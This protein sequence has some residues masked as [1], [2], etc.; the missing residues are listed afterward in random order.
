M[1]GARRAGVV[2][3]WREEASNLCWRYRG[4][5]KAGENEAGHRGIYMVRIPGSTPTVLTSY[6]VPCKPPHR[7]HSPSP[8]LTTN[9]A[10]LQ[11]PR[12]PC[13]CPDPFNSP[14]TCTI[15]L[16][17]MEIHWIHKRTTSTPHSACTSARQKEEDKSS[18]V[19]PVKPDAPHETGPMSLTT[20]L[21][22]TPSPASNAAELK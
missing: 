16:G 2:E 6:L 5:V 12:R 10:S 22:T 13:L 4:V 17:V 3:G 1:R 19:S 14:P 9:M 7:A 21:Q 8:N 18:T 15:P 11:H 20:T